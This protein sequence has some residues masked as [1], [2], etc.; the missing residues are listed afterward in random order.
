MRRAVVV[1]F[2]LLGLLA[3]A[4]AW[5]AAGPAAPVLGGAGVSV[6]GSPF[7]YIALAVGPNTL[8]E[9]VR[10]AGGTV[11]SSRLLSGGFG[12]PGVT[13]NGS[14]TGLSA[15][16]R[17]LVL[18][19]LTSGFAS[20][21]T[22]LVV[23]NTIPELH[24]RARIAL[25]GFYSV[26]AI[27]PTGYWLYLTHYRSPSNVTDYE[28]RAY[29]V[30]H[31]GLL[32]TPIADPRHPREKMTGTPVA[33]IMSADG[34]W[35]YTLYQ[36]FS[37]APFVHALDTAGRTAFCIDL[38]KL[39]GSDLSSA[40]LALSHGA[41]QINTSGRPAAVVDTRTFAVSAPGPQS[42]SP[43][44]AAQPRPQ[45]RHTTIAGG[46][47]SGWLWALGI[48]LSVGPIALV[49]LAR[50]RGMLP[51][52]DRRSPIEIDIVSRIDAVAGRSKGAPGS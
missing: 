5:A 38:P 41:L 40:T 22:N 42:A 34:R 37:G 52:R 29:D 3:P 4:G 32:P 26:D 14:T 48:V 7:N 10:R 15:D 39:N 47:D 23:L 50:R 28:I 46:S 27:S 20:T 9:Q 8:V 35:A 6:S 43:S 12:V 36:A 13:F 11:E 30:M 1:T 2:C 31:G 19:D 51:P 17:T 24:V 45:A 18:A 49:F 33:R 25:P 16:G 21:R 44:P